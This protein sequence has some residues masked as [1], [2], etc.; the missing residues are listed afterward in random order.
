M[1]DRDYLN[2]QHTTALRAIRTQ[3]R[4]ALFNLDSLTSDGFATGG[5]RPA[6]DALDAILKLSDPDGRLERAEVAQDLEHFADGQDDD[7]GELLN[8]AAR[9][10]RG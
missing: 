7:L 1:T 3:A 9:L 5:D 10:L 8:H 6:R 4:E 2:H